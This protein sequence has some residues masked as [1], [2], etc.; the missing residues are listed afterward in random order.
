MGVPHSSRPE[1]AEVRH[2]QEPDDPATRISD[3]QRDNDH[4]QTALTSHAVIDQAIGVIIALGGLRPQQG[5]DVLRDVSQHTNIKLR[6]IAGLVV[7]WALTRQL[8]DEVHKA[9]DAALTRAQA[10]AAHADPRD[11]TTDGRERTADDGPPVS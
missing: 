9:L 11:A 8:S 2:P 1:P 10:A 7:D 4:L 3:L 6:E 5:F